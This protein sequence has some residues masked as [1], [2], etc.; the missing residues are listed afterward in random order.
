MDRWQRIAALMSI[1][2][3]PWDF[4]VVWKYFPALLR[5]LGVTVLLTGLTIAIGTPIGVL[6]GLALRTKA[7][8]VRYSLLFMT[9]AV[10]SLPLLILILWVYYVVPILIG[11]PDMGSFG[12]ALLAMTINLSAFIAD[13]VR[14]SVDAFPK[15]LIEAGYAC[16]LSTVAVMRRIVVPSV[17]REL[18]PTFS[19][20]YIDM[21][22]LSSLASVISVYELL[23]TAD[24]IRSETFRAIEVFSAVA[25]IYLILVMPFSFAVRTLEKSKYFRR[26]A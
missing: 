10:R 16:G 21:L 23:H 13:I 25:V 8:V 3:Y 19:L 1:A 22:K 26:R 17:I 15:G 4:S 6:L 2:A 20:L 12:L 14:A 5:G 18:V 11:R 24:R 7:P 9:D